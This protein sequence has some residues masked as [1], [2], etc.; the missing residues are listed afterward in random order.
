[1]ATPQI[2]NLDEVGCLERWCNFR[3]LL[4]ERGNVVLSAGSQEPFE[5]QGREKFERLPSTE[6]GG[7]VLNIGS[8][9]S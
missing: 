5:L 9:E 6:R 8:I 4:R 2:P 7:D 1:M 3:P